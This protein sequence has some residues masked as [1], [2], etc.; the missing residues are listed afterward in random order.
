[1]FGFEFEQRS[2]RSADSCV[3]E[4]DV[5]ATKVGLGDGD[6]LFNLWLIGHINRLE[7]DPVSPA[8]VGE[9]VDQRLT[10]FG[11]HVADDNLCPLGHEHSHSR[12]ANA[13]RTTRDH[14]DAVLQ[15]T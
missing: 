8:G 9:F 5:E 12:F 4:D 1:M 7:P 2:D 15:A 3:V 11:V 13:G 6:Q 10:G 14:R